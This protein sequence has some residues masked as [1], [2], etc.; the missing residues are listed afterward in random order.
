MRIISGKH[1]RKQIEAPKNFTVRPTTDFAKTGLFNILNNK[2]DFRELKVLDLF[3][4]TGNIS[5]EFYSRGAKHITCIEKNKDCAAFITS[6][7]KNFKTENISIICTDVLKFFQHNNNKF[8]LIFA[9][10][11]FEFEYYT[12][13]IEGV[14]ANTILSNNGIFVLEHGGKNDFSSMPFFE[15]SRKYSTVHFSFFKTL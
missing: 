10:P 12:E 7:F 13:L 5:Y 1:A 6:T 2:V 8:D 11:P 4:G 15:E 3:A 14:F 9:D